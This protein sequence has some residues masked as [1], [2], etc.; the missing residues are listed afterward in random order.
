V[1]GW[2]DLGELHHDGA[3]AGIDVDGVVIAGKLA[4]EIECAARARSGHDGY[5]RAFVFSHRRTAG[6]A[7]GAAVSGVEAGQRDDRSCSAAAANVHACGGGRSGGRGACAAGAG[8]GRD[9]CARVGIGAMAGAGFS[10]AGVF[11]GETAARTFSVADAGTCAGAAEAGVIAARRGHG[12]RTFSA[13][14]GQSV[15]SAGVGG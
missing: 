12:E 9:S 15:L 3:D 14:A 7:G 2:V 1:R 11:S 6:Q 5:G 4:V 13:V 10:C 8:S